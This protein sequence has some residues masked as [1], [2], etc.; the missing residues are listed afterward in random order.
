MNLSALAGSK[1]LRLARSLVNDN[2]WK[3]S[4]KPFGNSGEREVRPA[5]LHRVQKIESLSDVSGDERSR[6]NEVCQ[7]LAR[8]F[9]FIR[10]MA[11][12]R[13]FMG[14]W[15]WGCCFRSTP[16]VLFR[17]SANISLLDI[18]NHWSVRGSRSSHVLH[19]VNL[20]FGWWNPQRGKRRSQVFSCEQS[21]KR[22][23]ESMVAIKILYYL[24]SH[25]FFIC[26]VSSPMDI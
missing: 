11:T 9:K 6:W 25:L 10:A 12:G 19:D 15:K 24:I 1:T 13:R 17:L 4:L 20:E 3:E 18:K 26:E 5:T 23:A 21:E 8:R 7:R 16:D 14:K 2:G 22:G